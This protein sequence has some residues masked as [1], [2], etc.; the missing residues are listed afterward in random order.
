MQRLQCHVK[1]YAW[2]KYGSD[3]EV[4]Q[5]F[6]AGH[7]NFRIDERQSYAEV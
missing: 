7:S 3:S 1:Q 6:R 2:G 5:L 4:S